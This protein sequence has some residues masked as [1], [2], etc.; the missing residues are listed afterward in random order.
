MRLIL[1]QKPMYVDGK[2]LR[3]TAS[4]GVT[5]SDG[6]ERPLD[7]YIRI[8]DEAL[9]MAKGQGRNCVASLNF[10]AAAQ[11]SLFPL[12]EALMQEMADQPETV[13]GR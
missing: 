3:V 8:A 13:N 11:T 9:Y 1:E 12:N 7:E 10:T 2:Q 6:T 4:F 5:I